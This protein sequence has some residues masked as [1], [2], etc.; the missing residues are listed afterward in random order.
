MAKSKQLALKLH[1]RGGARPGAGR[2]P[3]IPGKPGVSHLRRPVLASRFPVHVTL[4]MKDHVYSLRSRRC[5]RVI[6]RAFAA[7]NARGD[8]Q[9]SEFSVQGNHVHLIVEAHGA[10]SLARGMQSLGVRLARNLNRVM[11]RKGKV[12]ADRYHSRI[13]RTPT[14]VRRAVHYV[15]HNLQHHNPQLTRESRDSYSSLSQPALILAARTWLLRRA[16]RHL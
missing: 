1:P 12:L 10:L 9:L 11:Q 16:T 14:E 8:F 6:R 4:R 5:F 7:V 15:L 13:L 2:K 3:K